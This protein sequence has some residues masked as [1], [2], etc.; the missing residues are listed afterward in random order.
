[1]K[2]STLKSFKNATEIIY[3]VIICIISLMVTMIARYIVYY[4]NSKDENLDNFFWSMSVF[5][6]V[7]ITISIIR[8]GILFYEGIKIYRTDK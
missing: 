6:L 4:N 2:D 5:Y 1:M 7:I 3:T 8:I